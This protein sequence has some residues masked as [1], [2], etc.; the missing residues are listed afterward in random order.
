M[1]YIQE[2]T[3]HDG[4][5][6]KTILLACNFAER[7]YRIDNDDA[8]IF[9]LNALKVEKSITIKE[10]YG[11][12]PT[13]NYDRLQMKALKPFFRRQVDLQDEFADYAARIRDIKACLESGN[14]PT[15]NFQ[16]IAK[17]GWDVIEEQR[18]QDRLW[19]QALPASVEKVTNIFAAASNEM[20]IAYSR[21]LTSHFRISRSDP[22]LPARKTRLA[23]VSSLKTIDMEVYE[24]ILQ[25]TI[26]EVQHELHLLELHAV[27]A[28]MD[29]VGWVLPNDK[30]ARS[31]LEPTMTYRCVQPEAK[32]GTSIRKAFIRKAELS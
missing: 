9:C 29:N 12:D 16:Q 24:Q 22:P 5:V 6:Q 14:R 10:A 2:T 32:S 4:Y 20:T 17:E 31:K 27:D 26:E 28:C 23:P 18:K 8:P 1:C 19:E 30:K 3:Y 7:L 25:D 11:A 15:Y 13:C 21:M